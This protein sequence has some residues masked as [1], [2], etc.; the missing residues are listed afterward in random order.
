M[1]TA[2]L[3]PP[4]GRLNRHQDST[5]R[6]DEELYD[7]AVGAAQGKRLSVD[8]ALALYEQADLHLLGRAARKRADAVRDTRYGTF[9]VDRIISYTNAC[10][11]YCTFCAFY[12]P[13]GHSEVWLHSVDEVV[14]KVDELVAIGGTQVM[15]QGGLNPELGLSYYEDCFRAIKDKHPQVTIHS[16]TATEVNF[17]AQQE[18]MS[19]RDTLLAL[20][21]AGLDSLPGGGAEILIDSVR[22]KVSPLKNNTQVWVDTME[23]CHDIGMRSTATMT[24]GHMET[25]RQRIEHLDIL[26]RTQDRAHDLDTGGE[27]TALIPW[28]MS[29]SGTKLEGRIETA[30]GQEYLRTM[31]IGRLFLDNFENVQAGWIT[32]GPKL[33]QVA[34][35]FGANDFGG[36]LMEEQVVSATGLDSTITSGQIIDYIRQTG[37]IPAQRDTYYNVIR[38]FSD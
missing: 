24:Y 6:T 1:T 29:P 10:V 4:R 16:L 32:N 26:R 31:A 28:S 23:T 8:D 14:Q 12:R 3:L 37:R 11:A 18:D 38:T 15:M 33:A 34:M 13:P 25:N 5:D 36:V 30:T 27:F 22:Q 2:T 9:V 7:L 21:K 17:I 20:R 35:D 19:I